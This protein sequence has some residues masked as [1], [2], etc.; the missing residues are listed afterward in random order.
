VSIQNILPSASTDTNCNQDANELQNSSGDTLLAPR[1]TA[2]SFVS[3]LQSFE[4]C[5]TDET[6]DAP[7]QVTIGVERLLNAREVAES[8]GVS[9]RWVRDHTT[10]RSPRITGIKLGTLIRYRRA[11]VEIFMEKLNTQTTS[12]QN[13]FGV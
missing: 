13:R 5:E 3:L 12:R 1:P 6:I 4:N 8:L 9:E 2:Q 7:Q 11:D 10:R